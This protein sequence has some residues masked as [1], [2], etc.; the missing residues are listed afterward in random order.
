MPPGAKVRP[1]SA[2]AFLDVP[3]LFFKAQR[4][5]QEKAPAGTG[6]ELLRDLEMVVAIVNRAHRRLA[7]GSGNGPGSPSI[8][9][10]AVSD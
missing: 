10:R 9:S 2:N 7:G 5:T 1:Q 8:E 6:A 4:Q 3:D